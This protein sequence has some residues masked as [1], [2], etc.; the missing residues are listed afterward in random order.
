M[1]IIRMKSF[2]SRVSP[3]SNVTGVLMRKDTRVTGRR[4]EAETREGGSRRS[5]ECRERP[6]AGRGRQNPP[7]TQE[8]PAPGKR[9]RARASACSGR[10]E[11]ASHFTPLVTALQGQGRPRACAEGIAKQREGEGGALERGGR[12]A[13]ARSRAP[14]GR[15][16]AVVSDKS[17]SFSGPLWA[18]IQEPPP[19]EN[20]GLLP[21]TVQPHRP[22]LLVVC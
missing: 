12:W 3:S 22:V 1:G 11:A 15:Q 21:I 10:Q 18:Q 4:G 16:C 8:P 5:P 6:G 2:W 13:H 17:P 7:P 9:G 14:L 20:S 19:K